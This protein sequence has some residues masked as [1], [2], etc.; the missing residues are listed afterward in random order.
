MRGRGACGGERLRGCAGERIA[1][2]PQPRSFSNWGRS[3]SSPARSDWPGWCRSA[4]SDEGALEALAAYVPRYAAVVELAK[5]DGAGFPS[6]AGD[7]FDVVERLPGNA[8]TDFGAPAI[9]AAA[10]SKR[11][12]KEQA[13][14][15]RR[16]SRHRG[17]I[18]T[19]S[20]PPRPR[21]CARARAAA[22]VTAT[23]S[24]PTSSALRRR[25]CASWGSGSVSPRLV[26]AAA[27]AA[28][29][30]RHRRRADRALRRCA[31][32]REGLARQ[33]R[34][35]PHRLARPRPR[36]GDRGPLRIGLRRCARA[37][38]PDSGGRR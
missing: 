30:R 32:G 15:R 28:H 13:G 5:L 1:P 36:L 4:K 31:P 18:S 38:R 34:G 16:W 3:V 10:D 21:S 27:I 8:T 23:R 9:F 37:S 25:T 35:P 11:L 17:H 24:P 20:S 12:T 6:T 22:A 19:G 29:P 7:A 26:T 33:V 2:W 14:A